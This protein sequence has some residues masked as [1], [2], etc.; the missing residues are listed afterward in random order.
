MISLSNALH[1]TFFHVLPIV[2]KCAI[3]FGRWQQMRRLASQPESQ[4][5]LWHTPLGLEKYLYG[6]GAPRGYTPCQSCKCKYF[7]W[8]SPPTNLVEI[9]RNDVIGVA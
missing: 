7:S 4:S 2:I 1:A 6:P 8:D 9:L 3:V 5:C